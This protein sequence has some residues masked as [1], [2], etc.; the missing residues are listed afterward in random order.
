MHP[1]KVLSR[2]HQAR[3]ALLRLL[4]AILPAGALAHPIET[5][6]HILPGG[7]PRVLRPYLRHIAARPLRFQEPPPPPDPAIAPPAATPAEA[8]APAQPETMTPPAAPAA[9]ETEPAPAPAQV[10]PK[11]APVPAT[12]PPILP[13]DLQPRVRLEDFLPFF[14]SPGPTA[15]PPRAPA[16][17]A[18]PPSSVT[19]RQQ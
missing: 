11:P 8:A 3:R 4:L 1:K 12:P 15:E 2:F 17:A 6:Q 9:P 14:E 18:Q 7:P 16:P 13:D 5:L 19:Y 10:T